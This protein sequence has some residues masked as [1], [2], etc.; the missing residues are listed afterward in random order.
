MFGILIYDVTFLLV[1]AFLLLLLSPTFMLVT[2]ACLI[3]TALV[4]VVSSYVLAT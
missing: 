1:C 3:V 4:H 2:G